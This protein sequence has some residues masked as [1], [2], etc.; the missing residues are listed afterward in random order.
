MQSK[1]EMIRLPPLL[2]LDYR[3]MIISEEKVVF[4]N[5]C[6]WITCE[7]TIATTTAPAPNSEVG[8][9]IETSERRENDYLSAALQR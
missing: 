1:T 2:S 3:V 7:S 9:D 6:W 5:L 8:Q 4:L